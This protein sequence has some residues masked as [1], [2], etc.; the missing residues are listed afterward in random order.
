MYV[1]SAAAQSG[2]SVFAGSYSFSSLYDL[3]ISNSYFGDLELEGNHSHDKVGY[4]SNGAIPLS[5]FYQD[6][7]ISE[8]EDYSIKMHLHSS[9]KCNTS[10]ELEPVLLFKKDDNP[11]LNDSAI[12]NSNELFPSWYLRRGIISPFYLKYKGVCRPVLTNYYYRGGS[13][14]YLG[15][16]ATTFNDTEP[17]GLLYLQTKSATQIIGMCFYNSRFAKLSFAMSHLIGPRGIIFQALPY[18][19]IAE[20]A[21]SMASSY[22]DNGPFVFFANLSDYDPSPILT[23]GNI[24]NLLGRT[25]SLGA[26]A[27]KLIADVA[28]G[29][30]L[31]AIGSSIGVLSSGFSLGSFVAELYDKSTLDDDSEIQ[32]VG[33]GLNHVSLLLQTNRCFIDSIIDALYADTGEAYLSGGL[34]SAV[35]KAFVNNQRHESIGLYSALGSSKDPFHNLATD[36]HMTGQY[37]LDKKDKYATNLRV[38]SRNRG[39]RSIFFDIVSDG[40]IYGNYLSIDKPKLSIDKYSAGYQQPTDNIKKHKDVIYVESTKQNQQIEK[41]VGPVRAF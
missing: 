35:I 2:K 27:G 6:T 16:S 5:Y 31:A 40:H 13:A 23:V 30:V 14:L 38:T 22:Q 26:S 9:L 21:P 19:A 1:L 3:I 39:G 25:A 37:S 32:T 33:L 34:S 4:I 12:P 10:S 20:G 15:M 17:V 7:I 8:F 24:S 18:I 11:G 29:N 36:A 41:H 28:A